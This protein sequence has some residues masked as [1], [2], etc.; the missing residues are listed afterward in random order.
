MDWCPSIL[1]FARDS[2]RLKS[3]IFLNDLGY[4]RVG[5]QAFPKWH[6]VRNLGLAGILKKTI[7]LDDN[8]LMGCYVDHDKR[9]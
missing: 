6:E 4:K 5:N 7:P 8:I 2:K 1:A 9:H 3:I